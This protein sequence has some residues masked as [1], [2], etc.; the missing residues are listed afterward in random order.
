[1]MEKLVEIA[2][3]VSDQ[4]EVYS[5]QE[6]GDGVSFENAKLKDVGSKIQSGFSLRLIKDGRQ[7]FAYTKKPA[8]P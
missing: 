2:K 7:G 4:V 3:K 5:L 8:G 1:M 6:T